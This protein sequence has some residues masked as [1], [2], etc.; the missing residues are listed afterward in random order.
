MRSLSEKEKLIL[1]RIVEGK[2]NKEI[3]KDLSVS[4]NTIKVEMRFLF[5]KL[6]VKNRTQAA[7]Y[8]VKNN[9]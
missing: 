9:L 4:E 1:V 2:G 7:V 3:A 5:S 6:G 8:A